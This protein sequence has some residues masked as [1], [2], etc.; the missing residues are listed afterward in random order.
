MNIVIRRLNLVSDLEQVTS[1]YAEAPDYWLLAEGVHPGK[2]KALAFFH[3]T[4][5]H[6]DPNASARLGL[7]LN[8]RLSGLAELS[9]GFP[10]SGDAYLGLMILGPWAQSQGLGQRLLAH[11]EHLARSVAA[12]NLYLAVLEANPRGR[13]FW[14]REGFKE[15]GVW[16]A[17]TVNGLDHTTHRLRKPL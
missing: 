7:F 2:E 3:D 16:R 5:P 6:C 13:A 15:T 17:H 14:E 12:P 9:F 4:P 8:A 10:E 1:F 11:I